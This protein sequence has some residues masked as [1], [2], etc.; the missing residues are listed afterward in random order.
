MARRHSKQK[1]KPLRRKSLES[2]RSTLS[3]SAQ[4][5]RD[6]YWEELEGE[7]TLAGSASKHL[8]CVFPLSVCKPLPLLPSVCPVPADP[9][10]RRQGKA[11]AERAGACTESDPHPWQCSGQRPAYLGNYVCPTADSRLPEGSPPRL[12]VNRTHCSRN[13]IWRIS[14]LHVAH[15]ITWK[16]VGYFATG[17]QV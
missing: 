13:Q 11:Q 3:L 12:S 8:C 6:M 4:T 14:P 2:L 15:A 5:A 1:I 10:G 16:S 9:P 7:V 17:R